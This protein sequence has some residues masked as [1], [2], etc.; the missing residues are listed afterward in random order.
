MLMSS[1]VVFVSV[2][3]SVVI[4]EKTEKNREKN[5]MDVYNMHN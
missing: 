2:T 4:K 5:T 3:F 1:S